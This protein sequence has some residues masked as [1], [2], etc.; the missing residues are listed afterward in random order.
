[1]SAPTIP[2]AIAQ[3]VAWHNRHPLAQRIVPAQVRHVGVVALPFVGAAPRGAHEAAAV[4]PALENP[5][6][7]APQ[8]G[9]LRER[10]SAK[11]LAGPELV[12]GA[13]A[14]TRVAPAT[15]AMPSKAQRR[16]FSERFLPQPSLWRI[17]R[18]A[19][20]HGSA[21]APPSSL[22]PRRDVA[23]DATLALDTGTTW[24]FLGTA[25]I[26]DG[27]RRVRV[28][29]GHAGK[30]SILGPRLWCRTRIAALGVASSACVLLAALVPTM[31]HRTPV[32]AGA[33]VLA[34]AAPASAA[35]AVMHAA[36]VLPPA[37]VVAVP[38][39]AVA[40]STVALV[41]PRASEKQALRAEPAVPA[42]AP[43]TPPPPPP[44]VPQPPPAALASAQ[45]W[46][47]RIHP[48]I[49][50]SARNKAQQDSA[51]VRAAHVASVKALPP[52]QKPSKPGAA[53]AVVARSTTSRAASEMLLGF[54]QSAAAGHSKTTQ[55]TEVVPDAKGWRASWWPFASR[56]DAERARAALASAG[57]QA[58][59]V[60][61]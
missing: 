38:P 29:W 59:V 23:V 39:V 41:V 30:A 57:M 9:S 7:D 48:N 42:M 13:V 40:A 45:A 14:A 15:V 12:A 33:P 37:A 16:A 21:Q 60:E 61:F 46:P 54:M 50:H 27:E 43:V 26:E 4:E 49:N 51:A 19:W 1:M 36:V 31:L 25:A 52:A 35:S 18:F 5:A 24:R 17:A 56:Q 32:A 58:E 53:Y 22:G 47:P 2:Q 8:V 3:V 55:H 20:R 10:A 34:S 44:P 11:A 6:A 28:L